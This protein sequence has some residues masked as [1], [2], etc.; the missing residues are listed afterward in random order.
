M[1]WG[2]LLL[3]RGGDWAR[4]NKGRTGVEERVKVID[5]VIRILNCVVLSVHCVHCTTA[6][7]YTV[8]RGRREEH[9][10][11][12]SSQNPSLSSVKWIAGVMCH[13]AVE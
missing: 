5:L 6:G 2:A 4:C 13:Q 8:T 7:R 10:T 11:L 1:H 12:N 3:L 9:L